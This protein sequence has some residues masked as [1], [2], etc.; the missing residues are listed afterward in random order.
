ME[1]LETVEA[2]AERILKENPDPV[3]RFRLMWDV[4]KVSPNTDLFTKAKRKML[5]S[6]WVSELKK[7]QEKDG[8]WGKFHSIDSKAKKKIKTTE[9]GVERGLALGLE[10]ADQIFQNAI[11]YMLRLLEGKLDFPDRPERNDRWSAGKRLFVAATLAKIQ[12]NLPV[13]DDTWELWATIAARTFASGR[14]DS[15]AEIRAHRELTGASVKDSYLTINN[16]YALAL[17]GSRADKL[18]GDVE[19]ALVSWLWFSKKGIGYLEVPLFSVP[20]HFSPSVLDRWF[21]SLELVSCFPSWRGL[22]K[23]VVGWLWANR[24]EE[25]LWDFGPKASTSCYFPLSE[26]WRKKRNREHDH[27]VRV[28]TLLRKFYNLK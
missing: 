10:A 19:K 5:R 3:V 28:L 25:G 14:Y 23:D 24:G 1:G 12:P 6:R 2:T 17:L 20:V 18:C 7:E 27:S 26:S 4:L 13:L 22:A 11:R 8:G 16:R 21:A 9:I 15:D